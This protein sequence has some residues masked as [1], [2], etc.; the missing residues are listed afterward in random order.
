MDVVN[1]DTPQNIWSSGPYTTC[2]QAAWKTTC[3]ALLPAM[4]V[5]S[6]CPAKLKLALL[7]LR[8]SQM[9][10]HVEVH[11]RRLCP[12][13]GPLTNE[14]HMPA[15]SWQACLAFLGASHMKVSCQAVNKYL[16]RTSTPAS[17]SCQ[18]GLWIFAGGLH[19]YI[20]LR[21]FVLLQH[22]L[23]ASLVGISKPLWCDSAA[24]VSHPF[25][26]LIATHVRQCE[27]CTNRILAWL[28]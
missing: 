15:S 8:L 26:N 10:R 28:S 22:E 17:T 24:F 1:P 6:I 7:L 23:R 19:I 11:V 18:G 16:T 27:T 20:N 12:R 14:L 3:H 9:P 25:L 4:S 2:R 21:C 13:R 5:W